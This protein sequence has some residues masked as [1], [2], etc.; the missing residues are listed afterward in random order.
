MGKGGSFFGL[1]WIGILFSNTGK[2][3]FDSLE[4]AF[5]AFWTRFFSFFYAHNSGFVFSVSYVSWKSH[6][7]FLFCSLLYW[8]VLVSL[9]IFK[10]SF[11]GCPHPPQSW[12]AGL[13]VF[14][15]S[16]PRWVYLMISSSL[17]N[18][19][20]VS[21]ASFLLLFSCLFLCLWTHLDLSSLFG[22]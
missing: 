12:F 2:F 4:N 3:R 19:F 14:C 11:S 20:P 16:N 10:L 18:S 15:L 5:Y 17:L 8:A 6:Q 9:L 22:I 7:S 13:T 1:V 21:T